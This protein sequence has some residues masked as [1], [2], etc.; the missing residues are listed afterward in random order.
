MACLSVPL[1]WASA[2]QA[3]AFVPEAFEHR[4]AC[5]FGRRQAW[6]C[7]VR[8][9]QQAKAFLVAE[10]SSA[11]IALAFARI[12]R[13]LAIAEGSSIRIAQFSTGTEVV[14]VGTGVAFA[15]KMGCHLEETE[16]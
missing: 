15:A 7:R 3:W 13:T 8:S 2:P 6:S 11:G 16:A 9:R 1:A 5:T 12:T 10:G 4:T 14:S